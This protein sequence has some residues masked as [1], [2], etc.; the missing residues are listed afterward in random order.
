MTLQTKEHE[1]VKLRDQV[2][3]QRELMVGQRDTI[4]DLEKSLTDLQRA[5]AT[6]VGWW[7]V[8]DG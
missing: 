5:Y 3:S 1:L 7:L 4:R 2:E 8:V 6:Q